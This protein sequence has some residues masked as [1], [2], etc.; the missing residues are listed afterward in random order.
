MTKPQPRQSDKRAQR[1]NRPGPYRCAYCG[2]RLSGPGWV[3]RCPRVEGR[4]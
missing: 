3:Y 4:R 2:E 1:A